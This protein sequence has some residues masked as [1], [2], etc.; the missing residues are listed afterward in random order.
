MKI[1]LVTLLVLLF[2][3]TAVPQKMSKTVSRFVHFGASASWPAAGE[4]VRVS[5]GGWSLTKRINA[6]GWLVANVPCNRS[7]RFEFGLDFEHVHETLVA[8]KAK[9]IPIGL[10]NFGS[11][12]FLAA[13]MDTVDACRY[14]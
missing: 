9:P 5:V 12:E 8:C 13:D 4:R 11:G 7:I 1:A 2:A 6:K 10:F 14:C 3:G